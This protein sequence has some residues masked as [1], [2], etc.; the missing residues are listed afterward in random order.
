MKDKRTLKSATEYI[1]DTVRSFAP[2]D[3]IAWRFLLGN[4]IL[5]SLEDLEG[6]PEKGTDIQVKAI[7]EE[8]CI[9]Q[10]GDYEITAAFKPNSGDKSPESQ[11]N[12]D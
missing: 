4:R 2:I 10:L 11:L 7:S 8:T 1:E 6:L 3:E 5:E 9:L 12:S